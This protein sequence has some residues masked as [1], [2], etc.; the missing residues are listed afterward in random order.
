MPVTEAAFRKLALEEPGA[1]WELDCG[2]LR[3]KP[4]MTAAHNYVTSNLFGALFQQ[5]DRREFQVRS[6]AGHVRRSAQHYYIPDIFVVPMELVRPLLP[7]HDVLEAYEVPLPLVVEVWSRSTGDYDVD[8][9]LPEYQ[10]RGDLEIWRIHPYERTL[11]AWRRQ[12]DG[13]YT[14]TLYTSGVVHPIAL[15]GVSIDLDALFE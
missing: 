12:P 14:E 2:A 6:N 15:P 13:S 1:R 10:R 5:L 8:A 7:Q 3:Q 9:K 4:A 11:V